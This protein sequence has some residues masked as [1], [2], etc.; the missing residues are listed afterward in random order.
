MS[1]KKSKAPKNDNLDLEET[2]LHHAAQLA[3]NLGFNMQTALVNMPLEYKFKIGSI[4]LA[5]LTADF[6]YAIINK[7]HPDISKKLLDD[8]T[9]QSHIILKSRYGKKSCN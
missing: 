3:S 4:A 2:Y 5:S 9:E 6:C 7:E 1:R 8:I